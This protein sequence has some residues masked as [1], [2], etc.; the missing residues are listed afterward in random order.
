MG[1]EIA[2]TQ[3]VNIVIDLPL[4]NYCCAM[5]LLTVL[6]V[7]NLRHPAFISVK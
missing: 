7:L 5:L 6:V 2:G 3:G 4:K 1:C